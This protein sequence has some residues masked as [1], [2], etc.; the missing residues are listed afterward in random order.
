MKTAFKEIVRL[1]LCLLVAST[2]TALA[3]GQ[4]EFNWQTGP[5]DINL[6]NQ[7]ALKLPAGYA[8]LAGEQ[9]KALLRRE[10]NFPSDTVLG[11]I[12][13][14]QENN[15]T[16]TAAKLGIFGKLWGMIVPLALALKKGIIYLVIAGVA[17]IRGFLKKH[18][19]WVYH[20]DWLVYLASKSHVTV[21]CRTGFTPPTDHITGG[22]E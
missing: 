20:P 17:L 14:Q 10:G 4:H 13:P 16:G 18:G 12:V 8:F 5:T 22:S 1:I 11:L 9:A 2:G 6:S 15:N 3:Q 19:G 7:A 21:N